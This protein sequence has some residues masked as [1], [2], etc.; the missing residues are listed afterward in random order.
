MYEVLPSSLPLLFHFTLKIMI[1]SHPASL[2]GRWFP[3]TPVGPHGRATLH[4]HPKVRLCE[5]LWNAIKL[6]K[7][8]FISF[9]QYSGQATEEHTEESDSIPGGSTGFLLPSLSFWLQIPYGLL[10][11][12]FLKLLYR[13]VKGL[14]S[15]V[16]N[17]TKVRR[18]QNGTFTPQYVL[19]RIRLNLWDKALFII[20]TFIHF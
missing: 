14:R 20:G 7:Q 13:G 12:I 4:L 10:T 8:Y 1:L 3:L 16:H 2:S 15:D 6:E 11:N 19:L 17:M 18:E 9:S 5:C